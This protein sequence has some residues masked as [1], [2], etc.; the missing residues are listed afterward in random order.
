VSIVAVGL[1]LQNENV[2]FMQALLPLFPRGKRVG[3][4]HQNRELI[5]A[6]APAVSAKCLPYS[7]LRQQST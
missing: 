6:I 4:L 7:S 1:S 5:Q 3:T 2:R